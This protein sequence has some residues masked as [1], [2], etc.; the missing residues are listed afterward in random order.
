M[1]SKRAAKVSFETTSPYDGTRSSYPYVFR[2]VYHCGHPD[3][4]IEVSLLTNPRRVMHTPVS[5]D[6]IPRHDTREQTYSLERCLTCA[7]QE[8]RKDCNTK[9]LQGK[10]CALRSLAAYQGAVV[11]RARSVLSLKDGFARTLRRVR[12]GYVG[13]DE[14]VSRASAHEAKIAAL[15]VD[16]RVYERGLRV[17]GELVDLQRQPRVFG[18]RNRGS[19]PLVPQPRSGALRNANTARDVRTTEF[20]ADNTICARDRE[21]AFARCHSGTVTDPLDKPRS[22]SVQTLK[23]NGFAGRNEGFDTDD[24]NMPLHFDATAL[25]GVQWLDPD[26]AFDPD[27]GRKNIKDTRQDSVSLLKETDERSDQIISLHLLEANSHVDEELQ[28]PDSPPEMD[29]GYDTSES[30]LSVAEE[31]AAQYLTPLQSMLELLPMDA[32]NRFGSYYSPTSEK[33]HDFQAWPSKDAAVYAHEDN[34]QSRFSWTSSIYSDDGSHE[35]EVWWRPIAPLIITKDFEPPPPIPPKNPLRYLRRFSK[36]QPRGFGEET[37]ASRNILNLQLDLSFSKPQDKRKSIRSPRRSSRAPA[38][39]EE[40]KP[41]RK[42]PNLSLA[43]PGHI[44]NAMRNSAGEATRSQRSARAST[45]AKKHSALHSVRESPRECVCQAST[46]S[47]TRSRTRSARA[48]GNNTPAISKAYGGS[49]SAREARQYVYAETP[50]S[51]RGHTRGLS[52]PL[53][54][55]RV[56]DVSSKWNETM[57]SSATVRRS[58]IPGLVNDRHQ[59]RSPNTPA[60]NKALPP[61]PI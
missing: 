39:K 13:K 47:N 27:N 20:K 46:N 45:S 26:A 6:D 54:V 10:R 44:S 51:S 42:K 28:S 41:A 23:N 15:V 4:L 18:P 25:A 29:T 43:I 31:L 52:E 35:K 24:P 55:D 40:A 5:R 21:T 11:Q 38:R 30:G 14:T 49:Q 59:R 48:S 3:E 17:V 16:D 61:L 22:S 34:R 36:I 37:R 57:P 19:V 8:R 9:R 1:L 33:R 32:N 60:T 2:R 56:I 53:R 7:G 12:R 50:Q 58:C